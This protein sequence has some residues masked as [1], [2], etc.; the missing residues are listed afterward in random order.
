M[1]GEPEQA[2]HGT[3]ERRAAASSGI[4]GKEQQFGWLLLLTCVIRVGG[5]CAC[6]YVLAA[7]SLVLRPKDRTRLLSSDVKIN[8]T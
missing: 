6:D 3:K 4:K 8:C 7:V 5:G 2:V 1:W